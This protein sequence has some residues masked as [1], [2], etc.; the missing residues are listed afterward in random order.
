MAPQVPTGEPVLFPAGDTVQWYLEPSEFPP[1]DGWI[2]TYAFR[3]E[4][5]DGAL[6]LTAE[7]YLS[8]YLATIT[9]A[10]SASM[11]PG[12]W[13][14]E[15]HMS[16]GIERYTI[17]KGTV[18]VTP[19]LAAT[20]FSTDLRSDAKIAYDNAMEAWKNVKLGKTVSLNGRVYTQ[21]NI[22]DLI[23]YVDRCKSDWA[24]EQAAI[25]Q[26]SDALGGDP[27]KIYVR[28]GRV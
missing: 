10:Q 21:Q 3:G 28:F 7:T 9:A 11:R 19:N 16:L 14:W 25:E 6:N 27:R 20:N 23:L 26:A 5:G 4:R 18:K 8:G 24:N 2:L 15:A 13:V 1:G 12:D 17:G 22:E